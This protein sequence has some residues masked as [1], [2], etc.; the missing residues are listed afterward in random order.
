MSATQ[1]QTTAV[2]TANGASETMNAEECA[3]M[4]RCTVG[5]L[6]ELT[7][8]GEVPGLKIGRAW[9]YFR[10][11]LLAYLAQKARD[12][13]MER[14]S[15]RHPNVAPMKTTRRRT[16]PVLPTFAPQGQHP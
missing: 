2:S 12:E 5:Q 10:A 8:M 15:K 9:I 4:L 16:P 6:E 11:D 1:T 7:R 13:A 14:R 3:V